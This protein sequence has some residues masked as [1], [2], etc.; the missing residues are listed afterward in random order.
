MSLFDVFSDSKRRENILLYGFSKVEELL[1]AVEEE[2]YNSAKKIISRGRKTGLRYFAMD[3]SMSEGRGKDLAGLVKKSGKK[4]NLQRFKVFI[5]QL[6]KL[7][8]YSMGEVPLL[9]R[10]KNPSKDKLLQKLDDVKTNIQAA[11]AEEKIILA[12]L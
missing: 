5:N 10:S 9:V 3:I 1:E 4:I 12:E 8:D 7:M 2:D 6:V 11:I